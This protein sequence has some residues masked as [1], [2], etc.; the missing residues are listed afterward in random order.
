MGSSDSPAVSSVTSIAALYVMQDLLSI[1]PTAQTMTISSMVARWFTDQL[2][3][4]VV[5][6]SQPNTTEEFIAQPTPTARRASV[7]P[8]A[9]IFGSLQAD[10]RWAIHL[11]AQG[12]GDPDLRSLGR[13][14]SERAVEL[15]LSVLAHR[16]ASPIPDRSSLRSQTISGDASPFLFRADISG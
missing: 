11:Y 8:S 7:H 14:T 10:G 9:R 1:T 4:N 3:S 12:W 13:T 16:S 15:D 6:V 5:M 2:T